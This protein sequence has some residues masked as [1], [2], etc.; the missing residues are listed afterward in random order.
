MQDYWGCF[1]KQPNAV[2]RIKFLYL[3]KLGLAIW[4]IMRY[5]AIQLPT[6]L[7]LLLSDRSSI[8]L[9]ILDNHITTVNEANRELKWNI[10]QNTSGWKDRAYPWIKPLIC[11]HNSS[12]LTLFIFLETLAITL[13]DILNFVDSFLTIFRVVSIFWA[14]APFWSKYFSRFAFFASSRRVFSSA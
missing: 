13:T 14:S 6:Q 10:W 12:S 11:G 9:Y 4:L 7:R 8:W 5:I 3:K 2:A 1:I